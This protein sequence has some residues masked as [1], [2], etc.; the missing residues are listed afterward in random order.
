MHEYRAAESKLFFKIFVDFNKET[1]PLAA[2][3]YLDKLIEI[4]PNLTEVQPLITAIQFLTRFL[5]IFGQDKISPSYPHLLKLLDTKDL[6]L[7]KSLQVI[8]AFQLCLSSEFFYQNHQIRYYDK[9]TTIPTL[10]SS[11]QIILE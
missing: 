9:R 11:T 4:L 7:S 6:A 2:Q 10:L 1:N 8:F 5:T 3:Q